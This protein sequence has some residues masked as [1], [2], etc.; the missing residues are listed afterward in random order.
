MQPN[1]SENDPA[2]LAG[3]GAILTLRR[4]MEATKVARR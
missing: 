1:P 2:V 3:R 4:T